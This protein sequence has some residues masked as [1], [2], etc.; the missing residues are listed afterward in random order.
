MSVN[1]ADMAMVLNEL[2]HIRGDIAEQ[3]MEMR[4]F[5]EQTKIDFREIRDDNK[6]K[7]GD[8]VKVAVLEERLKNYEDIVTRVEKIDTSNGVIA[9]IMP[10][11]FTALGWLAGGGW[12]FFVG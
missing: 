12:K 5:K 3:K 11:L 2:K 6:N 10:Y 8:C 9:K 1:E 4:E 7:C